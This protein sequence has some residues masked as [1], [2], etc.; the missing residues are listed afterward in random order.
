MQPELKFIVTL[1]L[2][3]CCGATGVSISETWVWNLESI[4]YA[5]IGMQRNTIESFKMN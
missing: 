3:D 4:R 5:S 1:R 2:V